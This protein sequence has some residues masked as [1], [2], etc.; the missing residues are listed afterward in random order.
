MCGIYMR[1]YLSNAL[2]RLISEGVSNLERKDLSSECFQHILQ[3]VT[4]FFVFRQLGQ[5]KRRERN[6]GEVCSIM[7]NPSMRLAKGSNTN[8]CTLSHEYSRWTV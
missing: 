3:S 4:A 6:E 8:Y 2:R 1:T 5:L 7:R